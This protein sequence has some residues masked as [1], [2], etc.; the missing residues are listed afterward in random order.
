MPVLTYLRIALWDVA[1]TVLNVVMPAPAVVNLEA[2][3]SGSLW[4][5]YEPAK[6]T[7]SRCSCPAL[8]AMAN[9]GILNR[10]GRNIKFTDMTKLIQETFHF[11]PTFCLFVPLYAAEFLGRDYYKD[12]LDLSDLDVHN[13]IEHD[14]SF[15]REDVPAPQDKPVA[16]LVHMFLNNATGDPS[17]LPASKT[18]NIVPS[19]LHEKYVL[20]ADMSLFSSLRRA[21]CKATNGQYTM[22]KSHRSFSASNGSTVLTFF[23]PSPTYLEP[24]LIEERLPDFWHPTQFVRKR[25]GVTIIGFNL[26]VKKVEG[27]VK[28][29]TKWEQWLKKEGKTTQGLL[30]NLK[31]PEDSRSLDNKATPSA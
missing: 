18:K 29:G 17:A 21:H 15:F 13:K 2:G 7:D 8:N 19:A 9:H 6:P 24:F 4:P 3:D 1:L 10:D 12:T 26:L 20:P 14:A 25:H 5:T 30:D 22:T 11:A 16:P 23:H 28:E 31:D 27:G